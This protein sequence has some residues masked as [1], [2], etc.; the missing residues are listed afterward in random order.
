MKSIKNS[1]VHCLTKSL[2][3]KVSQKV[4]NAL[5]ALLKI[6]QTFERK[7]SRTTAYGLVV[8]PVMVL[9]LNFEYLHVV[10]VE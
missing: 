4:S 6:N 8:L 9:K 5:K 7:P 2:F 10:V 3:D 1:V